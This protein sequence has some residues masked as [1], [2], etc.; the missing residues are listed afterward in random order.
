MIVREHND[1]LIQVLNKT[2]FYISRYN[3]A[4]LFGINNIRV[5]KCTKALRHVKQLI[6]IMYKCIFTVCILVPQPAD[7]K[8]FTQARE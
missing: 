3:H 4:E 6:V 8:N 7:I 1:L 2:R 5:R